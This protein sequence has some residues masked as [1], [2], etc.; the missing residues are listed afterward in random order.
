MMAKPSQTSARADVLDIIGQSV[1]HAMGLLESLKDETAALETEN[2][3]ALLEAIDAKQGCV[4]ELQQLDERRRGLCLEAG[5]KDGPFQ[6]EE[7]AAW[8]DQDRVILNRWDHLMEVAAECNARNLTNG[9]ILR[10]RQQHIHSNLAVLRGDDVETHTYHR[11]GKNGPRQQV[12][13]AKA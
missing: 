12:A 11:D 4:A 7:L 1:F 5:F 8:C 13:I 6:M 9:S 10:T 3:E 2:P